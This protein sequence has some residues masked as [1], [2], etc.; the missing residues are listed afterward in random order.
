M[1]GECYFELSTG[2]FLPPRNQII[3]GIFEHING[4]IY[5]KFNHLDSKKKYI[6]TIYFW[7][8]PSEIKEYFG[9]TLT[10]ME[11]FK[12]RPNATIKAKTLLNGDYTIISIEKVKWMQGLPYSYE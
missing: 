9:K 11:S 4:K 3:H 8:S 10:E 7:L 12:C 2:M 6:D 1:E 5:L